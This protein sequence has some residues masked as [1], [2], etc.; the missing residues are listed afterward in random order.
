ML[1]TLQQE[2]GNNTLFIATYRD[3]K[4]AMYEVLAELLEEKKSRDKDEK[5]YTPT[6]FAEKHQVTKMTLN[7]WVKAGILKQTKYGGKVYYKESNLKEG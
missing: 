1:D 3:L 2:T 5:L 6:E 7:R 4:E